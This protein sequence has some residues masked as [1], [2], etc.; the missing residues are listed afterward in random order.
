MWPAMGCADGPA[1]EAKE[2]TP[3]ERSG[4]DGCPFLGVCDR[5]EGRPNAKAD[6]RPDHSVTGVAMFH[7][8]V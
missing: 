6:R 5:T 8:R 7:P 3:D 4:S 2:R 1:D